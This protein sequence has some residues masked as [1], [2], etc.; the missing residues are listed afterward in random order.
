MSQPEYLQDCFR[1]RRSTAVCD[2]GP[3][4]LMR[5]GVLTVRYDMESN[6]GREWTTIEFIGAVA[7]LVTPEFA[8][9]AIATEAYSKIAIVL[10]SMWMAMM[11]GAEGRLASDLKHFV[12]FFDHYGSVEVIARAYEVQE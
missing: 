6:N 9:K 3:E 12:V 5:P 1:L 8:T 10:N 4:I 2:E 11:V 7:L